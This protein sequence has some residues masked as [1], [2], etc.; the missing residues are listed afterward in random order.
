MATN[1]FKEDA[2]EANAELN[3]AQR[4]GFWTKL[5]SFGMLSNDNNIKSAKSK[6]KQCE[7]ELDKYNRITEAAEQLDKQL[8]DYIEIEGIRISKHTFADINVTLAA[9]Y[10]IDWEQL[11]IE[12]LERDSYSCS[13]SNAYCKGPLQIHHKVPLSKGGSNEL[14]NLVTLCLYH[15]SEKHEHLRIKLNGNIWSR[16]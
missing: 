9:N 11:R 3:K 7:E 4:K 10:P 6:L 12:V 2:Q 15:H 8:Q 1:I 16:S 13:E 5:F 14:H